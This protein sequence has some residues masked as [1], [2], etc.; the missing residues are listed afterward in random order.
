MSEYPHVDRTVK[1][2]RSTSWAG[3]REGEPVVVAIARERRRQW[4]FA[5]HVK[6]VVSNEEWIEV[7]GGRT[8]EAITRSFRAELIFPKSSKSVPRKN[9]WSFFDAPRFSFDEA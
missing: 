9:E 1:L 3:V 5:A 8:G 4:V 7:R 6:N 2:V